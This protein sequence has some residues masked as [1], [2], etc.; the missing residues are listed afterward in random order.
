VHHSNDF[1]TV[2]AAGTTIYAA[3]KDLEANILIA[4]HTTTPHTQPF[5][6]PFSGTTWVS[7]CQKRN[8]WTSWCKGR[9]TKADTPTIWLGATPSGLTSVHLYHLDNK[10]VDI[11]LQ[12]GQHTLTGQR[13]ANFRLLANQWAERRLVTQRRHG[14]RA[15]RRN[16]CNAGASRYQGMEQPPANILIP[17]ERQLSALQFCRWQ[18]IYNET[19]Q[20]TFRPLSSKLSKRWQI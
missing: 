20:Q 16:V 13:A 3:F 4:N 18:F 1:H 11:F 17:L 19:L 12:E 10:P 5:Y 14:C 2:H 9:L 8:F 7:Q 15:M 6:G